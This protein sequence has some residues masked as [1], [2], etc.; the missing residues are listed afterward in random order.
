MSNS[1]VFALQV[2]WQTNIIVYIDPHSYHMDQKEML[3]AG[4]NNPGC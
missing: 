2:G 1:Y 4:G 3:R